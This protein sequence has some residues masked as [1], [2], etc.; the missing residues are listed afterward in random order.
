MAKKAHSKK[1]CPPQAGWIACK[2]NGRP[3]PVGTLVA[4]RR[5]NGDADTFIAGR[6]G[7][8]DASGHKIA[9]AGGCFCAWDHHDGGPMSVK[10]KAYRVLTEA[11]MVN[12]N[13]A[14]F[15]EWL[16]M[17]EEELA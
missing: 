4:V 14:M 9:D 11:G 15:Q 3:V 17:R 6:Q 1:I 10:V 16:N 12:R 5:F 8:L 2:G 7:V 13:T